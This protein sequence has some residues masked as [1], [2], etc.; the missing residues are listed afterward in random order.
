MCGGSG[1]R[2][3]RT[4]YFF[5]LEPLPKG[6]NRQHSNYCNGPIIVLVRIFNL[7]HTVNYAIIS[8]VYHFAC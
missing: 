3:V 8:I 2:G 6:I 4:S 7:S 1:E 5:L